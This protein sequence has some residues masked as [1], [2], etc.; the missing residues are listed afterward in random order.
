MDC[1]TKTSAEEDVDAEEGGLDRV[2]MDEKKAQ[3]KEL[4]QDPTR[5]TLATFPA[6]ALA[7]I[8]AISDT[9]V[10]QLATRTASGRATRRRF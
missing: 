3:G 9:T 1:V 10:S 8:I 5:R 2:E 6:F 7:I 4:I